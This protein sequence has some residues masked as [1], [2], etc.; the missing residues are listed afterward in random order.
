MGPAAS[1]RIGQFNF[2]VALT[3]PAERIMAK[4]VF[5]SPLEFQETQRRSGVVEQ[6]EQRFTLKSG[7]RAVQYA[8]L[9]GFQL[10][11]DQL[12]YNRKNSGR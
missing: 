10:T 1:E 7:E 12:D 5:A 8:I 3:D 2:F 4:E 9:I 6:I 11:R